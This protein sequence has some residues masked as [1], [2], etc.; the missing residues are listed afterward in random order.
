MMPSSSTV[1]PSSAAAEG[2]RKT[3]QIVVAGPAKPGMRLRWTFTRMEDFDDPAPV[4]ATED[5]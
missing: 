5:S 1:I 4:P 2:A 3:L